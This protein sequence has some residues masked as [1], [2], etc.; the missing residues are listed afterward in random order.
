MAYN[1]SVELPPGIERWRW[2]QNGLQRLIHHGLRYNP[3]DLELYK[4]T[5]WIYSHK[6]GRNLDDAHLI[7]KTKLYEQIEAITGPDFSAQQTLKWSASG[8]L[9]EKNKAKDIQVKLETELGLDLDLMAELEQDPYFGPLD[10]RLPQTQA[11]FWARKGLKHNRFK[12]KV[13][14]LE[15]LTYQAQ[16]HLLRQGRVI[17]LPESDR[18]PARVIS[19]PDYRQALPMQ[20]MFE[21][22][23][24]LFRDNKSTDSGVKSAYRAFLDEAINILIL[25]GQD[26]TAEQLF[27][28]ANQFIPDFLPAASAKDLMKNQLG[29]Q[30]KSM[31]GDEFS[32][33]VSSLLMRH[34]WWMGMSD[35]KQSHAL[36]AHAQQIWILNTNK[37]KVGARSIN[38]SFADIKKSILK[39]IFERALFHPEILGRLKAQMNLNEN[40]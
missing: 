7:Y 18:G 30:L 29:E 36:L 20:K 37:N 1:I 33:V 17:Y 19:W 6:M 9:K 22:Q 32:S 31:S 2:V 21:R 8:N 3:H 34:F 10:W 14:D 26:K 16:Q 23:I 40:I 24:Q 25:A 12:T 11:I 4:Q 15:R 39:D 5:A 27:Q 28:K 35:L 13:I 38:R